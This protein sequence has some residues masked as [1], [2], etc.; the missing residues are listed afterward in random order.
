MYSRNSL[1]MFPLGMEHC[2]ARHFP[3]TFFPLS[4]VTSC[5]EEESAVYLMAVP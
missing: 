1:K 4:S 5:A 3:S 2:I